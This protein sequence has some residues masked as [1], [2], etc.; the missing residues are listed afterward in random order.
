VPSFL[1]IT[2]R[3]GNQFAAIVDDGR[4]AELH[5]A[6]T[7]DPED[8]AGDGH[9]YKGRIL[10]IL[11]GM[12]AAFVDIGQDRAAFVHL[13]DLSPRGLSKHRPSAGDEAIFQVLKPARGTKGARVTTK[14]SLAG[15]HLVFVPGSGHIGVS[16]RVENDDERDRLLR[17]VRAFA[18]PE[19]GY[20]VRTSAKGASQEDLERDSAEL[21]KLWQS[22]QAA[23][24][25]RAKPGVIQDELPF[26][27][28]MVRDL[29]VAPLSEV[30]VDDADIAS[31]LQGYLET[32][33]L[34]A[35]ATVRKL[36][37]NSLFESIGLAQ[38]L[39]DL[40]EKE[41]KLPSGGSIV[42]ESTEAL[43]AIDVNTGSFVGHSS[44]T[45]TLLK[46]N[47]EAA[48]EVARQIR[49]RNL[50]GVIVI[51]FVGLANM[52]EAAAIT[53]ALTQGLEKDRAKVRMTEM[54]SLGLV[55]LSRQRNRPPLLDIVSQ[56]CPHCQGRG[57]HLSLQTSSELSSNGDL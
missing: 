46:A 38:T 40:L 6:R 34:A 22:T 25:A 13:Q 54:N 8:S 17:I 9:L 49:L 39:E 42:I 45:E 31:A 53:R 44:P 2:S 5:I 36:P 41:V 10:R 48:T 3:A 7:L 52:P 51:D 14:V 21:T 19:D 33:G 55:C 27:L 35:S 47:I 56:A 18:K 30:R 4:I 50:A 15:R 43:T 1:A 20:V 37:S 16:R 23:A 11:P 26:H 12:Q 57:R 29:L 32:I 28:R 24:K